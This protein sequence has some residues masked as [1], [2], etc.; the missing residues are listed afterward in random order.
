M[1]FSAA[2]VNFEK[3][4]EVGS[5]K[6]EKISTKEI[7]EVEE[8]DN[9]KTINFAKNQM[10]NTDQ[11]KT[12]SEKDVVNN[13]KFEVRSFAD[14]IYLAE[15]NKE[16]E[17]KYDL[18]RNVKLANFENG[19]IDIN[20]NENINKNFIKKL[21]QSLFEWTGKRWIITLSKN[22]DLKTFHEKKISN[23]EK[24]LSNEKNSATVKEMLNVFPD[25]DLVE[26][27]ED[28]DE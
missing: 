13:K 4:I 8:I 11:I 3:N 5:T 19:N 12:Y 21:S 9:T 26:V 7:K 18:E 14:L 17:L 16:M 1:P 28:K 2:K 25:A 23:K 10:K 24:L 20:F 22:S 6:T 15:K 27:K